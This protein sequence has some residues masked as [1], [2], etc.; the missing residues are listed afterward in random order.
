MCVARLYILC[1]D[2]LKVKYTIEK[3]EQK[4]SIKKRWSPCR[5]KL[6]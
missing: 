2:V 5:I 4:E 3:S 1:E 6:Q